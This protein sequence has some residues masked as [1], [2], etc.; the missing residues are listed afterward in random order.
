MI[1][2]GFPETNIPGDGKRLRNRALRL[3]RGMHDS[4]P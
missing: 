3:A 2:R 4:E 1:E